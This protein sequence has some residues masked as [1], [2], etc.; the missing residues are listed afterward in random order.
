VRLLCCERSR[1]ASPPASLPPASD[2]RRLVAALGR[3]LHEDAFR[4]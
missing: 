2:A 3:V 1:A 4:V